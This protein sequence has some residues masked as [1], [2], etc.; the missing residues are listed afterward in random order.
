MNLFL[1][2]MFEF[3]DPVMLERAVVSC[4][5]A[6]GNSTTS[7]VELHEMNR[8]SCFIKVHDALSC[9]KVRSHCARH[10]R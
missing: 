9:F 10:A 7:A 4:T 3:E 5:E 6:V 2:R 1:V 8:D